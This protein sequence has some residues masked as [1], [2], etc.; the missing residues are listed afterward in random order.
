MN[1]GR[2]VE[3]MTAI[4][5][6]RLGTDGLPLVAL[7]VAASRE[8][9]A[10]GRSAALLQVLRDEALRLLATSDLIGSV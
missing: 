1:E 5:V 2:I 8:S 9:M 6:A 3:A 7:G 4:G 10:P